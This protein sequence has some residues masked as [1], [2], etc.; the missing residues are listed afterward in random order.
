MGYRCFVFWV[1]SDC[2]VLHRECFHHLIRLDLHRMMLFRAFC[3]QPF[4]LSKPLKDKLSLSPVISEKISLSHIYTIRT[5]RVMPFEKM[6]MQLWYYCT[7]RNMFSS[8]I[9]Y[10]K[11]TLVLRL[12]H[13]HRTH[14]YSEL[15]QI[16]FFLIWRKIYLAWNTFL[17]FIQQIIQ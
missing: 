4:L 6:Y 7:H 1:C 3:S 12:V 2:T 17:C 8:L 11:K 16:H 5:F 15:I 14:R 13:T 9:K 10:L